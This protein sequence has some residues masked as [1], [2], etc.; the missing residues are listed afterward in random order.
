MNG[1]SDTDRHPTDIEA[2][3]YPVA[4][5]EVDRPFSATDSTRSEEPNFKPKPM[6]DE[7]K[8]KLGYAFSIAKYCFIGL[9]VI[10][11]IDIILSLSSR[12][13]DRNTIATVL[14]LIRTI[15]LLAVGFIFGNQ[16][17]N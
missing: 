7:L 14:D 9:G 17:K 6:S 8:T 10:V 4:T 16:S 2:A 12:T 5:E 13:P 11:L 15:I 3:L 1:A